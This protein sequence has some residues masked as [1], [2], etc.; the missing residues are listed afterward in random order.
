MDPN[1]Q[2]SPQ[3]YAFSDHGALEWDHARQLGQ[4][5]LMAIQRTIP[6]DPDDKRTWV[7]LN[8]SD[9]GQAPLREC[10]EWLDGAL[11]K[12]TLGNLMLDSRFSNSPDI[13]VETRV[14]AV[15][16]RPGHFVAFVDDENVFQD[17]IDRNV[18]LERGAN[19][20]KSARY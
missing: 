10:A 6:P 5:F 15:L 9:P 14:R 11:L 3:I 1:P 19:V 7:H 2:P 13:S 18:L 17:I 20:E 16:R 12:R 4:N 8:D